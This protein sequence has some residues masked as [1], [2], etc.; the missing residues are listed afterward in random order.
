MNNYPEKMISSCTSAPM[1]QCL[2]TLGAD[3]VHA[4]FECWLSACI[5]EC[6]LCACILWVLIQCMCTLSV[7][8][9]HV[10]FECWLSACALCWLSACILWVLKFYNQRRYLAAIHAD[11]DRDLRP[12]LYATNKS[13][14]TKGC[15][16]YYSQERM[17]CNFFWPSHGNLKLVTPLESGDLWVNYSC[18][19]GSFS[20]KACVR[21]MDAAENFWNSPK[22]FCLCIRN[23]AATP[24]SDIISGTGP[25]HLSQFH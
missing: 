10:H 17:T 11:S 15:S 5:F 23:M 3:S 9:V 1:D 7:H 18:L 6:W 19:P 21:N 25:K 4:Y 12:A 2:H 8:S 20:I 22:A 24:A 14:L 13:N 16:R